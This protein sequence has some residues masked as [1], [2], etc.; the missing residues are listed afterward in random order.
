MATTAEQ[1]QEIEDR[2]AALS[3]MRSRII[4]EQEVLTGS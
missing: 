1:I 2:L 3:E 4:G